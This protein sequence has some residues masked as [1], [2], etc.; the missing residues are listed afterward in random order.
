[1]E[2]DFVTVPLY[3]WYAWMAKPEFV[4]ELHA[5]RGLLALWVFAAHLLGD[6]QG[7]LPMRILGTGGLAV[8]GF[9]MLSGFVIAM[10]LWKGRIGYREFILRRFFRLVPVLAVCVA[11]ALVVHDLAGLRE[12]PDTPLRVLLVLGMVQGM[13]PDGLLTCAARSV[14]D[15][16]WSIS[17]EWQFY[18]VAPALIAWIGERRIA[19]G[20]TLLLAAGSLACAWVAFRTLSF[21]GTTSFLPM[22]LGYF[23]VG[24]LSARAWLALRD[25]DTAT[26]HLVTAG[27]AALLFAF[28]PSV[29]LLSLLP[30]VATLHA[31]LA[32]RDPM[33]RPLRTVLRASPLQLLGSISF[34]VYL[35]HMPVIQAFTVLTGAI[36]LPP[37]WR[38]GLGVVLTVIVTLLAA[39]ALWK[40]VEL[41]C[42]ALGR[43]VATQRK[44]TVRPA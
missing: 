8:D 27:T 2:P 37:P 13:V 4:P 7:T 33:A 16:A 24:I 39:A 40:W 10:M 15:P 20:R 35:V 31:S 5:L 6:K 17:L 36:P 18:L 11:L 38:E 21:C 44:S 43:R 25:T 32:D 30:W 14:L 3:R 1:M 12:A 26:L 28:I 41:P 34:S 9:I 29:Q 19:L 42:I 23:L 22:R